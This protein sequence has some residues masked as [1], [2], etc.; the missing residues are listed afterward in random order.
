MSKGGAPMSESE[1]AEW[2]SVWNFF[3][4]FD[5]VVEWELVLV[6]QI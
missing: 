5:K 6:K 1:L 4:S 2:E 3:D